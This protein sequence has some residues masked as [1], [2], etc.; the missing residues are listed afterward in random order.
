LS[1]FFIY[2]RF[3]FVSNLL[4]IIFILNSLYNRFLII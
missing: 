3:R 1:N 4:L 2:S